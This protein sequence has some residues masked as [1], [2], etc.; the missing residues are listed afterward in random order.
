MSD[1]AWNG[2]RF[3]AQND[4]LYLG[5]DFLEATHGVPVPFA[6]YQIFGGRLITKV[7]DARPQ[8]ICAKV[9]T[10]TIMKGIPPSIMGILTD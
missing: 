9:K 5:L 7:I 10:V 3:E 1:F 6:K 8:V 2:P 4:P